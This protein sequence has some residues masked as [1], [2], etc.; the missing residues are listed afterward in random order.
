MA[1]L[2]ENLTEI[3]RQKDTYILPENLK[4]DVTVFGITGTYEG[5]S[6]VVEGIKQ[7]S[8]VE[9]MQSDTNAKEGDLAVVYDSNKNVRTNN[10]VNTVTFPQIVTLDTVITEEITGAILCLSDRLWDF[11]VT[12]TPT[13]YSIHRET[14]GSSA[15]TIVEYS[16]ENGITYNRVTS[17]END[18]YTFDLVDGWQTEWENI[19]LNE[20][21]IQYPPTFDGFYEHNGTKYVISNT[22]LSALTSKD[23]GTNKIV[24][25]SNGIIK[26]D[27]SILIPNETFSDLTAEIYASAKSVYDDMTPIVITS[28]SQIDRNIK[29]IPTNKNGDILLDFSQCE[30][31]DSMFNGCEDISVIPFINTSNVTYFGRAFK[32]CK[33]LEEIALID[34][35]NATTTYEMFTDCRKLKSIPEFDTSKCTYMRNFF[36]SCKS[37]TSI[38]QLNT[39]ITYDFL[40]FVRNCS[41]LVTVP[42]LDTSK[43]TNMQNMFSNCP[44]LSD[45]SLNNILAMCTNAS[46]YTRTKTLAYIGLTLEQAEKCMTMSNY[47]AFLDAGWTTGY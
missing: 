32:G 28:S 7:F 3:K 29:V 14:T 2:T 40:G 11:T 23:I 1:S 5:S 9:E 26:G 27:G 25:T 15:L 17:L 34:L 22:Q 41:N 31:M 8:T 4:K 45:E 46:S 20:F 13:S 39:S 36:N 30:S 16:S 47:Q 24:Y 42:I 38:P 37:I 35:S 33:N 18:L 10:I 21:M 19:V 6:S 12:L 43:A 44:S